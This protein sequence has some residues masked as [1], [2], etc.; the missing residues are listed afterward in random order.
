MAVKLDPKRVQ[1]YTVASYWLRTR[2]DKPKE[3]EQFLRE[4]LREN[5]DSFE[6]LF[7]LGR[8]QKEH[9]GDSEKT[10]NLWEL[11]LSKWER[12]KTAGRNPD[13]ATRQQ[14][15]GFL[16][17]LEEEEGNFGKAIKYFELLKEHSPSKE[18]IDK[19]IAELK[20]ASSSK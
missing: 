12:Q 2:L 7:E 10:R 19:R 13:E 3:A 11:A 1:T 14:I 6:I 18:E 20:A 15:L 17:V 5:P 16:A 8:I 4:G 9:Y